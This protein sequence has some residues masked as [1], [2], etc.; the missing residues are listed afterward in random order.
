MEVIEKIW[1][2]TDLVKEF[3]S[4]T[5]VELINNE[6]Y[7]PPA[8]SFEHQEISSELGFLLQSFVKGRG[9]GKLLY[10]P[11][12]VLL[13]KY[14]VV[15]PDIL[16]VS[17]DNLQNISS[18]GL[19]GV[20]DLVVEIIS[21]STFHRDSV[22]KYQL[23]ERYGVKEYWLIE[24]ANQVIEVFKLENGKYALYSFVSSEA[25]EVAKSALLEGF[26]VKRE[27][28]FMSKS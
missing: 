7:M 18:R 22:E 3:P 28:V 20:P 8:P 17:K 13:D 2:Y 4:E 9:I 24:P 15:Q 14:T 12:D 6:L 1:T 10:V 21:P 25:G 23:Y 11:F 19:E 5:R 16:F 27:E 26:E